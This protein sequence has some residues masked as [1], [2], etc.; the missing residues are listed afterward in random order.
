MAHPSSPQ[1]Q[2]TLDLSETGAPKEGIARKSEKRL[3]VQLQVFTGCLNPK[4]IAGPLEASGLEAVVYLDVKDP[5]G[6]G[7][8]FMSEDPGVFTQSVRILLT[9]DPF[10][11]F[12]PRPEFTMFGRTYSSGRETDLEDWLLHKPRRNAL[13]PKWPWAIWYPLRRRPE[14]ELLTK[15]DQGK[16]LYE[17][18][19]LGIQYG[20]ADFAH[21]IRLACY[22]LDQKDNEFVLGLVG[23]DLYP[24]SRLIQDMRKTQQTA[25]YIE[26]L[27]PFFV[28]KT[29]WQSPLKL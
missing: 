17:H 5:R 25:K 21:D 26:S 19:R 18:A 7:V 23:P 29:I 11:S 3:F 20:Q 24:L 4:A 28:G 6:I 12:H 15:E 14:F 9:Q 13:N 16:I 27:G 1:V 10:I 2:E 22:G 8:L